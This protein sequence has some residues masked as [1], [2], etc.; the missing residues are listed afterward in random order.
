MGIFTTLLCRAL[1]IAHIFE[2]YATTEHTL[3]ENLLKHTGRFPFGI[4]TTLFTTLTIQQITYRALVIVYSLLYYAE[5]LPASLSHMLQQI[6]YTDRKPFKAYW[7]VPVWVYSLLY[8]VELWSLPASLSHMLQ[9][10]TYTD[11][12]PFKAYWEIL[13]GYFTVWVFSHTLLCILGA[14]VICPHL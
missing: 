11:R 5:P 2:P 1:V 13:V 7:E 10:I 3:I 8:Y 14:L 6:T 4:F 9:Q 12:K